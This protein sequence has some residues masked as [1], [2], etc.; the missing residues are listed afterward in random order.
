MISSCDISR[1]TLFT[2]TNIGVEGERDD[3]EDDDGVVVVAVEHD[4]D[5]DERECER[6]R[7]VSTTETQ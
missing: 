3:E 4:D 2:L 1:K 7:E 5:D 6:Q